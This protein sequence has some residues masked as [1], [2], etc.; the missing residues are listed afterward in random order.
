MREVFLASPAPVSGIFKVSAVAGR[1]VTL[2]AAATASGDSAG[3]ELACELRQLPALQLRDVVRIS[4]G[5]QRA[6]VAFRE[7]DKHHTLFVTNQ[8]NSRC[9][10]CSQPPTSREDSWLYREAKETVALVDSPPS[11]VGITGGEPTLNPSLLRELLDFALARWP[12]TTFEVL[13]NARRLGDHEVAARVLAGLPR[14]RVNWLVPLYGASDE[15]H[16]F[17]VQ[18]PGAFDETL[19]GLLNLQMYGQGIQLRTVLIEPVLDSLAPL[20][21]FI[22]KNLPFVATVALMGTEPIGFALANA[23]TCLVDPTQRAEELSRAVELL[24][25]YGLRPVLMNLPL[26]KLP[27]HLRPLAAASISDWKNEYAPACEPCQLK[28]RCSGFFAWDKSSL[29]RTGITPIL[30]VANV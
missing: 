19:G 14:G 20:C 16:D 27:E 29:H 4:E 17:V 21:E 12:D 18:A 22:G 30:Q 6:I 1:H 7:T 9:L 23:E 26:C 13:T 3:R 24:Q 15:E 11:V 25:L 2:I 10:M 5:G 28:T 8:C